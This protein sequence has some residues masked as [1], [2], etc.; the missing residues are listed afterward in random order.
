MK[1]RLLSSDFSLKQR[2]RQFVSPIAPETAASL[3][4]QGALNNRSLARQDS[5]DSDGQPGYP[6]PFLSAIEVHDKLRL[7]LTLAKTE[8]M[9]FALP[10]IEAMQMALALDHASNN[11]PPGAL[12]VKGW[13]GLLNNWENQ[14]KLLRP[15]Q[16]V[17]ACTF[18]REIPEQMEFRNTPLVPMV[19]ELVDIMELALK[20]HVRQENSESL[21]C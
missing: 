15:R 5:H 3:L 6:Q 12:T 10:L 13:I 20:E 2:K 11:A 1:M 16:L 9:D 7:M 8:R 21:A 17:F 19:Q 18:F 4:E 14:L